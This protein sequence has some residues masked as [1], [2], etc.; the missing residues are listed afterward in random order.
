MED[1]HFLCNTDRL[2]NVNFLIRYRSTPHSVTSRTP[3]EIFLGRHIRNRFSLLK[4][5][6]KDTV[7]NKQAEQKRHHDARGVK[8]RS[9]QK[10]DSV[11][12][13]GR[14]PEGWKMSVV[15]E[16]KGPLTYVVRVQGSN[17]LVHVHADH[18]VP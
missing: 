5:S 17:W 16:V 1:T 6:L 18:V 14:G 10:G 13:R 12:I 15:V 8:E 11:A 9:F 4:P 2:A 7:E 3:A